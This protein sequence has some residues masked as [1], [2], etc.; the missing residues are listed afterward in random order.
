MLTKLQQRTRRDIVI[1]MIDLVEKQSFESIT[2]TDICEESMLHRSTFYRYFT[3]KYDLLYG[4]FQYFA[5]Q[6]LEKDE[7]ISVVDQ[8]V[9]FVSSHR[10]FLIHATS[11]DKHETVYHEM[12]QLCLRVVDGRQYN[13]AYQEDV[14]VQTIH[15][16]QNQPGKLIM[17]AVCGAIVGTLDQW[18]MQENLGT[19]E[20]MIT[21]LT[22]LI[23]KM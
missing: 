3:D 7:Q 15:L 17:G 21:Y 13:P 8:L 18:L 1:A 23:Q 5:D 11:S 12:M 16:Q 14:V 19:K 6:L 4:V 10:T 20:S 9:T 2:I 22:Q